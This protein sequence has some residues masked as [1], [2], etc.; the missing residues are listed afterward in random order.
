MFREAENSLMNILKP[1]APAAIYQEQASVWLKKKILTNIGWGGGAVKACH[2]SASHVVDFLSVNLCETDL[3]FRESG[4]Y[5][6]VIQ[7]VCLAGRG[8][9]CQRLLLNMASSWCAAG[10]Q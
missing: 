7:L 2:S 6:Q 4:A 3:V 8:Q 1:L 10:R 9:A 5:H